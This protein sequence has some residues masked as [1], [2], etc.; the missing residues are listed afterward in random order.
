MIK[1]RK[2]IVFSSTG[3]VLI[4]ISFEVSSIFVRRFQIIMNL[5]IEV[6]S[7]VAAALRYL[8]DSGH[9][10]HKTINRKL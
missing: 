4:N 3:T 8:L 9:F 7:D 1:L 10:I 6:V 5:F 2:T